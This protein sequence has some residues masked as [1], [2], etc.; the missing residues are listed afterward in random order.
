M[1][2]AM[3]MAMMSMT[4]MT[5]MTID[6]DDDDAHQADASLRRPLGSFG[7]LQLLGRYWFES[8]HSQLQYSLQLL[9]VLF[10]NA[11]SPLHRHRRRPFLR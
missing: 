3:I 2:I 8:L 11:L 9:G 10:V 7:L 1:M 4:M 5:M 6:D